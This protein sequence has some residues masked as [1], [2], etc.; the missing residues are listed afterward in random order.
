MLKEEFV[1]VQEVV[2][3]SETQLDGMSKER[4]ESLERFSRFGRM[5]FGTIRILS[6]DGKTVLGEL[7]SFPRTDEA[8]KKNDRERFHTL[9]K[10]VL[11]KKPSSSDKSA[12]TPTLRDRP[13][14]RGGPGPG[15]RRRG[16]MVGD[17]APDIEL[18]FLA[19][20]KTFKLS[21]NFER[22]PTVLLF[23]SFT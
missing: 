8:T 11:D 13:P 23:H 5:F 12:T 2:T 21:D 7:R 22:R 14:F 9:L 4:R 10:E 1:C 18:K 16:P 3:E 6:S 20:E 15:L 19:A 17:K